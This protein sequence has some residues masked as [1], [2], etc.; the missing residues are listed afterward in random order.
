MIINNHTHIFASEDVP[1]GFLPLGLCKLLRHQWANKLFSGLLS[2]IIPFSDKDIFDRY[3]KFIATGNLGQKKIFEEISQYYPA[4]TLFTCLTMDMEYM[5]AGKVPRPYE[6]QLFELF[7]LKNIYRNIVPFIHIDPRREGAYNLFVK[8]IEEYKFKG[9]KVY[10]NLGYLPYDE[11][12]LPIYEYCQKLNIPVIAHGSP[13][14]PVHYRGSKE[15]LKKIIEKGEVKFDF[16]GKN[17]KDFCAMLNHPKQWEIVLNKYPKL[18]VC[19]AHWGSESEWVRYLDHNDKD[20]NWFCM[21]TDMLRKYGNLYTDI[22]FTAENRNI[23]SYLSVLLEDEQLKGKILFGS[24]AYMSEVACN[25][26]QFCINLRAFLREEKWRQIS[27]INTKKFL[28]L[29]NN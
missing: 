12:M 4:D 11:R 6:K 14:N 16:R 17:K 10:C 25:E 22:S 1:N 20:D 13:Y 21:V 28:S 18:K 26:R 29:K 3:K 7:Q 23:W 15:E 2:Y 8:A 9:L 5:G 27:E 19:L 24:D